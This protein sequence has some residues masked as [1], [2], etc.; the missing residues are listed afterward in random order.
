VINA[1]Q[2]DWRTIVRKSLGNE[3]RDSIF[4]RGQFSAPMV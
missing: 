1:Q 4:Q 2:F 3:L